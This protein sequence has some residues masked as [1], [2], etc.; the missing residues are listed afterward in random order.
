[1]DGSNKVFSSPQGQGCPVPSPAAVPRSKV[2]LLLVV[3]ASAVIFI[4]MALG[5]GLGLGLDMHHRG[6]S[7][8]SSTTPSATP[9]A[10]ALTYNPP[11]G[12]E[13]WRLNTSEYFLDMTTW[14][15]N[16]PPQDRIYNFTISEIEAFPDG[17]CH[18]ISSS[19]KAH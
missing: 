4:A 10:S 12:N 9:S 2:R 3:V 7:M 6:G 5:L 17:E 18:G 8:L 13:S 15:L 11:I 19:P 14:D 1:M 16:A